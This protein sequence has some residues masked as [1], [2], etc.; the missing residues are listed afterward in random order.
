VT[1]DWTQ[2]LVVVLPYV[3]G[4]AFGALQMW[5]RLRH[6]AELGRSLRPRPMPP[7][8]RKRDS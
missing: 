2:V 7:K 3:V 6:D 8:R 1:I 4:H 5:L